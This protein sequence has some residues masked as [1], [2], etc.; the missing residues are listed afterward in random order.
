[1][2]KIFI[3]AVIAMAIGVASGALLF[4]HPVATPE[5][6]GAEISGEG[7]K[8]LERARQ[9]ADAVN[10]LK[11]EQERLLAEYTFP[12]EHKVATPSRVALLEEVTRI[13]PDNTWLQQLEIHGM[14]VSM[15]GTT[16][17]SAKLIGLFEQSGL[18][19]GASY[20]S[21]LVK[22]RENEERFQLAV[23]SKAIDPAAALAAQQD[24]SENKKPAKAAGKPGKPEGKKP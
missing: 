13:L 24:L 3:T 1:M 22:G 9:Q 19:E 23:E 15:Q 6:G 10:V 18:L 8:L 12:F 17:S 20:K 14:E 7:V 4:R 16:S 2:K 21:P 11:Q 5:G